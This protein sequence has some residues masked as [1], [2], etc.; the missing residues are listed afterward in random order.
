MSGTNGAE[1][2][3]KQKGQ[4]KKL[5]VDRKMYKKNR[6]KAVL[7]IIVVAA[8]IMPVTAFANNEKDIQPTLH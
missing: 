4:K 3:Y 2:P 5:G 7:A 1:S 6:L 8:F